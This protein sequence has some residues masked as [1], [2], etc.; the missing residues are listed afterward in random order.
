MSYINFNKIIK[1]SGINPIINK[2]DAITTLKSFYDDLTFDVSSDNILRDYRPQRFF[3]AG[4]VITVIFHENDVYFHKI[5]LGKG[6]R[7]YPING[8]IDY[9]KTKDIAAHFLHLQ[10]TRQKETS[11]PSL[12]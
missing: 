12:T 6:D 9:L 2:E 8:P 1:V 10:E 3:K 5:T 7:M 11:L 4:R